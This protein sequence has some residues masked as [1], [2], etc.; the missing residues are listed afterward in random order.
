MK[1]YCLGR[2]LVGGQGCKGFAGLVGGR[3]DQEE[4][5]QHLKNYI[6]LYV[7]THTHTYEVGQL[8]S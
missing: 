1:G 4:G 8:I 6:Y 3:N 5:R 2:P 7:H